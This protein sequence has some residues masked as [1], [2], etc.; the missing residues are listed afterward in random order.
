MNSFQARILTRVTL[1]LEWALQRL[2]PWR[3]QGPAEAPSGEEAVPAPPRGETPAAPAAP[4]E[5][6][7]AMEGATDTRSQPSAGDGARELEEE[8]GMAPDGAPGAIVRVVAPGQGGW[9]Q[10]RQIGR[11]SCRERV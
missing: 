8:E 2:D 6:D 10:R 1:V 11:A 5:V 3:T 4:A 9:A 7:L